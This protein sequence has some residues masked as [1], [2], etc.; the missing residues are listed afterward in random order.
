[1]K[2]SLAFLLALVLVIGIA[3]PADAAERSVGSLGGCTIEISGEAGG[4]RVTCT[5]VSTST[6]DIIGVMNIVLQEKVNG[7]WNNINIEG[8]ADTNIDSYSGSALY[9]GAVKG[10][11]YRAYCTHYAT[12][13]STTKTLDND[14]GELVYN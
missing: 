5:T 12:Y 4:V 13:G 11:T 10:R 9:T 14:T 6:A 2:K 3:I 1:M 7:H 8:G